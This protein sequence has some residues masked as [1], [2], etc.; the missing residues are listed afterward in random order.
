MSHE[1]AAGILDVPA[2]IDARP[3]GAAQVLTFL[4]CFLVVLLDGFDTAAIGYIAPSLMTEWGVGRAALA[5]VLSAALFGLAMG[6]LAAGPLADRYGR[7]AVLVAAVVELGLACLASAFE[8]DLPQLAA[9]R[10]LTGLGLG[11]AIPNAVTLTSEYGPVRRRAL[12]TNMMFSGFP[13]GAALGGF[14]AAWMIPTLGW[15]SVLLLG[16][17][18]PLALAAL[19]ALLL[20]ESVRYLVARGAAP[21]RIHAVLRLIAPGTGPAA[22]YDLGAAAAGPGRPAGLRLVLSPAY[23]IGL[24]MLW[25]AYLMGID[26]FGGIAGSFLVAELA[27]TSLPVTFALVAVPALLAAA[28]VATKRNARRGAAPAR[29]AALGH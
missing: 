8:A 4:L 7:K 28:A 29:A 23:R 27:G 2:L 16:G 10:F 1:S 15:R 21:A 17:A 19:L 3:I 13:L 24:V 14:L 5:P 26:R 6:A 9:L 18:A 25:A 20:P 11:A 22:G 12:L